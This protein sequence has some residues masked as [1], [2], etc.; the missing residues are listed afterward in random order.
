MKKEDKEN[1]SKAWAPSYWMEDADA[2][3]HEEGKP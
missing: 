2:S 1:D 3:C